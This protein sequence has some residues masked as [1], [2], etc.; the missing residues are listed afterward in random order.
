MTGMSGD[1]NLSGAT[2]RATKGLENQLY[3]V[4]VHRG[5]P[6]G[7]PLN[8]RAQRLHHRR[9]SEIQG[10]NRLVVDS[11]GRDEVLGFTPGMDRDPGRLA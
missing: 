11:V 3:R 1:P 6:L 4:E 7:S 8:G 2:M 5:G 9:V 10:G